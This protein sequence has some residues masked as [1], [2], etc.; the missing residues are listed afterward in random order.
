MACIPSSCAMAAEPWSLPQRV[1]S[2]KTWGYPW[3]LILKQILK[4]IHTYLSRTKEDTL[5]LK[6]GKIFPRNA[7]SPAQAVWASYLLERKCFRPKAIY[8]VS[9]EGW[10]TPYMRLL[11]PTHSTKNFLTSGLWVLLLFFLLLL[12]P[13]LCKDSSVL[14]KPCW[15]LYLWTLLCHVLPTNNSLQI[16]SSCPL[17][18]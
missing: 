9:C 6:Q 13:W 18:P 8:Y 12:S 10:K 2:T 4:Q 11:F 1:W 5:S 15:H 16:D 7:I 17:F 14:N 3:G